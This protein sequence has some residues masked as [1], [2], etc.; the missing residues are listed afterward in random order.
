MTEQPINRAETSR[1]LKA[2]RWLRGGF[3]EK[4]QTSPLP[5]DELAAIP[6]LELNKISQNRLEE[7]ERMK[8]DARTFDREKLEEALGLPEGWFSE[9][10][11]TQLLAPPRAPALSEQV[12]ALT[13]TVRALR[14]LALSGESD[15]LRGQLEAADAF[16]QQYDPSTSPAEDRTTEE[17]NP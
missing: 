6:V 12:A 14:N 13:Q 17:G 4:G 16:A 11:L 15:E 3:N 10:D 2:A 1:R 5:T 8:I 7:I 9:T